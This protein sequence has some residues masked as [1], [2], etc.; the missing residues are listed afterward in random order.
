MSSASKVAVPTVTDVQ[1]QIDGVQVTTAQGT[2]QRQVAAIGDP[3]TGGNY[4]GIDSS[5]NAQI[6]IA[7]APASLL[8][9]FVINS[10]STAIQLC[11]GSSGLTVKLHRL[12]LFVSVPTN[13]TFQN[14]STPLSGPIPLSYNGSIILDI[15]GDPWYTTSSGSALNLGNSAGAQVSGTA[16]YVQS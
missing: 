3:T 15:S 12:I 7:P 4:L 1:A 13:I 2:V 6:R 14:A 9:P 8:T 5:G 16:W 11:A 10:T